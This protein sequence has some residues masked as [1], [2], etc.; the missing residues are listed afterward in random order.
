MMD[1]PIYLS[2]LNSNKGPSHD[3]TTSFNPVMRLEPNRDYFIALDEIAMSYSWYNVSKSYENNTLKYSHDSGK[4]WHTIELPDGNFSYTELNAYIQRVL[5]GAKHSKTGITIRFIPAL[6]KVL[7]EV[8]DGYQ[9]DLQ[10]GDFAGLIGFTKK[11]VT[12]TSYGENLPDI[13]RSVDDIY[14]RTNIISNSVVGGKESDVLFRF[15]I[16]NI[17]L[18]YPF[19]IEPRKKKYNKINTDKIQELRIYITDSLNRPI[20]LNGISVSLTLLLK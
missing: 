17:P 1:T 18:S 11:I 20:D 3:F 6:F 10:T 12:S 7:M 19:H 2:S 13:T 5:E 15:S 4:T 9:V 8:E 16:D 14:I